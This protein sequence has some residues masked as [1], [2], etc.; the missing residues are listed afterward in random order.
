[1][2]GFYLFD[3]LAVSGE[4]GGF[5]FAPKSAD[6][7][8]GFEFYASKKNFFSTCIFSRVK[9]WGTL[10]VVLILDIN[11]LSGFLK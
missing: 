3:V 11:L 10:S 1:M 7:S 9:I 6:Y 8:C 4:C 5:V 2:P